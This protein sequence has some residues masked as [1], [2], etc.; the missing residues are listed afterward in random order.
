MLFID[1]REATFNRY[2]NVFVGY[3]K[4]LLQGMNYDRSN[5]CM[6]S[7][8][9]CK[10]HT[11]SSLT[12]PFTFANFFM[13]SSLNRF[14]TSLCTVPSNTTIPFSLMATVIFNSS[15]QLL[16]RLLVLIVSKIVGHR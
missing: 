1:D 2:F 13:A 15:Q 9:A 5:I 6:A 4:R 10:N 7:F 11:L 12:I 3:K 8:V 14:S 16:N